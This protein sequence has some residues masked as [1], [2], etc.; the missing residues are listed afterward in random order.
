LQLVNMIAV[1][2]CRCPPSRG[3][4]HDKKPNTRRQTK[5]FGFLAEI[6]G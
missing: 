3:H 4:Y 5:K 1:S 2:L 6:R